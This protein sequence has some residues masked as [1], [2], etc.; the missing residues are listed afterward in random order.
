MKQYFDMLDRKYNEYENNWLLYAILLGITM[1]ALYVI[2]K[3][4]FGGI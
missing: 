1:I 3:V 4:F 2:F